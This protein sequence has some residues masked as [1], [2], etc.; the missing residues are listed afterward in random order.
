MNKEVSP[1]RHDRQSDKASEN[2]N[3]HQCFDVNKTMISS[4]LRLQFVSIYCIKSKNNLKYHHNHQTRLLSQMNNHLRDLIMNNYSHMNYSLI[5]SLQ[6]KAVRVM[7][8]TKCGCN[9]SSSSL[10]IG[11]GPCPLFYFYNDA[12]EDS[13][14]FLQ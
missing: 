12:Y 6:H 3:Y 11:Q 14:V 5:C 13:G 8:Y 7:L 2:L 4:T 9:Q 1:Y 10:D